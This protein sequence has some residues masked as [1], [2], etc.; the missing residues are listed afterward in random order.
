M[1]IKYLLTKLIQRLLCRKVVESQNKNNVV[2]VNVDI[3]I[4]INKH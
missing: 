2:N 1:K 3:D 4:N